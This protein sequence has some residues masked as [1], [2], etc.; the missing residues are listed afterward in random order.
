MCCGPQ[1]HKALNTTERLNR[2]ELLLEMNVL[3]VRG[4]REH[5]IVLLPWEPSSSNNRATLS[6]VFLKDSSERAC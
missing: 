2:T 4:K 1:G 5:E 6:D 3:K